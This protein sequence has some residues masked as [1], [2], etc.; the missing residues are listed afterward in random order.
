MKAIGARRGQVLRS[1]L[2]SVTLYGATGTAIGLG[3]G[4]LL[5]NLLVSYLSNV[6]TL[7]VLPLSVSPGL[8]LTSV[9]VGIGVPLLAALLPVYFGTRIT[10]HE[11]LSSFGLQSQG[12]IPTRP[13]PLRRIFGFLPQAVQL[14]L[15]SLFRRRTRAAL[16]LLAL[17]MAGA[18]F[19]AVQTTSQSFGNFLD[20]T[21][22]IYNADVFVFLP[23]PAPQTTLDR[24]LGTVP[25]IART[26]RLSQ[27]R[28]H[29]QWGDGLL[30]GVQ[31]DA[32][33]YSRHMLAG[34][35][36]QPGDS[37][38]VVLSDKAA[39]AS[40][41]HVGDSIAFHD[42]LHSTTW[43]II[44]ITRDGNDAS[45]KLGVIL[46]PIEQVN[47]FRNLPA[48]Y[49]DGLLVRSTSAGPS[50]VDALATRIDNALSEAGYAASVQTQAQIVQSNNSQFFI[51]EA[52]LYAVAVIVALVGA[53]GLFNALAMSVLE[54]RREI[55]I[56]R[57]MGAGGSKV[58]QVF[59]TEGIALG[60]CAW[61]LGIVVGIPA[62]YGFVLLLSHLL[63]TIPFAFDPLSLV[64]MLA[65]VLV[66]ATLAS[67]GP[68]W[69][70][71]RMRIAQT[72]RYE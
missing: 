63:A 15:R 19:L 61:V 24:V 1:Y 30:T 23:N 25:G 29:T 20:Q 70:A 54:R 26:E 62:A 2:T 32:Q 59:W 12:N 38:V 44:G 51:V 47:A 34:R 46:A 14:G 40:N 35:W 3:L 22:Q 36:F 72:L 42:D 31:T 7:D 43:H 4:I 57:S 60:V 6:L 41:L 33:L 18:C 69:G 39:A 50:V 53:I 10:V 37:G 52:L 16:T 56:L 5:G 45:L 9:V 27:D 71:G 48:G 49:T 28:V 67:I 58:A 65:F 13:G 55:G 17:A 68:A 64:W 11:A 21:L 8:V 66:V